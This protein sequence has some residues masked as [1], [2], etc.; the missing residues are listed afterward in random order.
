MEICVSGW[1]GTYFDRYADGSILGIGKG[2][3]INPS[4]RFLR[5]C[6]DGN[7]EGLVIVLQ[8]C[9][10]SGAGFFIGGLVTGLD[11]DSYGIVLMIDEGI[12]IFFI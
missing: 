8:D 3:E 12:Q 1:L 9:V 5:S 7:L 4:C 11:G 10:N 6:I 2:I